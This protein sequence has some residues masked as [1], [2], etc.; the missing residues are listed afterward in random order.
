MG[1]ITPEGR[2]CEQSRHAVE[3]CRRG[4]GLQRRRPARRWRRCRQP[5]RAMGKGIRA[6]TEFVKEKKRKERAMKNA[7]P[8]ADDARGSR[9]VSAAAVL[10]IAQPDVDERAVPYYAARRLLG[11]LEQERPGARERL[12]HA[13]GNNKRDPLSLSLSPLAPTRA[14][15]TRPFSHTQ[16]SRGI[17]RMSFR[18]NGSG[19]GLVVGVADASESAR[20]CRRPTCARGVCTYPMGTSTPKKAGSEKGH[21]P[22]KQLVPAMAPLTPEEDPDAGFVENV[23]DVEVEVNMDRRAKLAFGLPGGPLVEAPAKPTTGRAAV[24]VSYGMRRIA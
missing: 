21:A 6:W 14:S 1:R 19:A 3:D 22:T 10:Q 2:L 18:I 8:S 17:F 9:Q 24:G 4:E 7:A 16:V 20:G 13:G 15:H 11:R 5:D 12:W 23:F